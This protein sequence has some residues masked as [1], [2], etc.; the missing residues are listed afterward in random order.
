MKRETK[1]QKLWDF[2]RKKK[3]FATHDVIQFGTVNYDNRADRSKRDFLEMGLI[4]P[5]TF[6]EL[7]RRGLEKSRE[8]YY[9]VVSKVK[10][11]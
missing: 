1:K 5:L 9:K 7:K 11:V 2:M 10:T 3:V 4:R 8:R 6:K